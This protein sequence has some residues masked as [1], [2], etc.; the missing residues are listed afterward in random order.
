RQIG[1]TASLPTAHRHHRTRA[2]SRLWSTSLALIHR[3]VRRPMAG[4]RV[5]GEA[6]PYRARVQWNG[7]VVAEST[8][9]RRVD[10]ADRAPE[11]WFPRADVSLDALPQG[12]ALWIERDGFVA[13][14]PERVDVELVDGGFDDADRDVTIKRFPTWGDAR[15]L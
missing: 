13:F 2:V 10:H 8:A 6:C 15:D 4:N 7:T 1:H 11:L 12:E 3:T 9:G 5:P 14:E